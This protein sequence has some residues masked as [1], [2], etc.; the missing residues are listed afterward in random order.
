MN[1]TMPTL[2]EDVAFSEDLLRVVAPFAVPRA[3]LALLKIFTAWK[4][5][6]LEPKGKKC[7]YK[8]HHIILTASLAHVYSRFV[9]VAMCS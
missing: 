4:G 9:P 8:D 2:G 3:C 7:S 1:S 6:L 5:S